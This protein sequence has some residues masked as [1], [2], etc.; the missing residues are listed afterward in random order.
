MRGKLFAV[1]LFLLGFAVLSHADVN[2][3]L[4]EAKKEGSVYFFPD[5]TV[6]TNPADLLLKEITVSFRDGNIIW[7]VP[8]PSGWQEESQYDS[9]VIVIQ[10]GAGATDIQTFLRKTKFSL[11]SGKKGGDVY[12]RICTSPTLSGPPIPHPIPNSGSL[13][14]TRVAAIDECE[15]AGAVF[16]FESTKTA[17]VNTGPVQNGTAT[18]PVKVLLGDVITYEIKAVNASPEHSESGEM[19][20]LTAAGLRQEEFESPVPSASGLSTLIIEDKLPEGLELVPGSFRTAE[21]K[22][23]G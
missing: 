21:L 8:M 4:N 3:K 6:T 5:L 13:S 7:P 16:G 1:F 2:V 14:N 20:S 9:K 19:V 18:A 10:D 17:S 23:V 12:I 15:D 11:S 22:V